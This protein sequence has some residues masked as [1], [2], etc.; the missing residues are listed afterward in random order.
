MSVVL[1]AG[2]G[3]Q[4]QEVWPMTGAEGVKWPQWPGWPG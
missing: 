1:G 3:S 2:A 4:I